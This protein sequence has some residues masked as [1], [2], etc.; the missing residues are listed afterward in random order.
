M[1]KDTSLVLWENHLKWF[2]GRLE[3]NDVHIFI[4]E[5]EHRQKVGQ[6]RVDPDFKVSVSIDDAFKGKGYGIELIKKGSLEFR[7]HSNEA[8]V[9]EVKEENSASLK[10]FEKAGYKKKEVFLEDEESYWRFIFS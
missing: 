8:L 5:N 3:R 6:F 10:S 7:K 1:F 4:G 9:A 2:S